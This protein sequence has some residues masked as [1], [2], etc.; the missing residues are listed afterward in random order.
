MKQITIPLIVK[1]DRVLIYRTCDSDSEGLW[2]F[3]SAEHST[4]PT[5][6]LTCYRGM[7]QQLSNVC[8]F[9]PAELG[10]VIISEEE[11]VSL[12]KAAAMKEMTSLVPGREFRWVRGEE[13]ATL[14]FEPRFEK[15]RDAVVKRANGMET[16]RTYC[17]RLK[18]AGFNSHG[19]GDS[20]FA[21]Q[22]VSQD[23]AFELKLVAGIHGIRIVYGFSLPGKGQ[24]SSPSSA[25]CHLRYEIL[26]SSEE[27]AH[28]AE[29]I[30]TAK[31]RE[32][33][34]ATREK[35]LALVK[36]RR[37]AFLQLITD[38]LKPL[39]FKKKGNHWIFPLNDDYLLD[40]Y[41]QKSAY[42]DE[43]YFNVQID[44]DG[45]PQLG[46]FYWKRLRWDDTDCFDWALMPW[47]EFEK[48]LDDGIANYIKPLLSANASP[49]AA[50]PWIR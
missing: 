16:L 32:H 35:I 46:H 15:V 37:N 22:W 5:L 30:I 29:E 26:I 13:L 40:F 36:V 39:G 6:Y 8:F 1:N 38:R 17:F 23:V 42:C 21:S 9:Q 24:V 27:D 48:M 3:I 43:Y 11:T 31:Y 14:P 7:Q 25:Y 41:A 50:K 20:Y 10:S 49:S 19:S 33:F 4:E 18:E 28:A 47:D 12:F 2:S 44:R 34:G 45:Q